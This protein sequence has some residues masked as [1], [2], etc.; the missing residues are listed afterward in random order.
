M[1]EI[2]RGLGA[3]YIA[4]AVERRGSRYTSASYPEADRF[5][6]DLALQDRQ[7]HDKVVERHRPPED[8]LAAIT[9]LDVGGTQLR[10]VKR[11]V[12]QQPPMCLRARQFLLLRGTLVGA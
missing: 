6:G 12:G 8:V 11:G 10:K 5:Q 4:T 9:Q 1:V 3:N 2:H 7:V